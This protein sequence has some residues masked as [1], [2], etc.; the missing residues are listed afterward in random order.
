LSI[1]L[2]KPTTINEHIAEPFAH[3]LSE[4]GSP[5]SYSRESY[6]TACPKRVEGKSEEKMFG[7]CL[8]FS[9]FEIV[10]A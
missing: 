2:K 6:Q 10:R 7:V 1:L 8:N 5:F 3:R 4:N 9:L